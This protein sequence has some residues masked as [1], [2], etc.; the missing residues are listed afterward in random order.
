M[1]PVPNGVEGLAANGTEKTEILTAFFTPVLTLIFRSV[2][3]KPWLRAK[4]YPSCSL[5]PSPQEDR[6]RK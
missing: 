4:R 1:V 6:V 2:V 3:G 5:T